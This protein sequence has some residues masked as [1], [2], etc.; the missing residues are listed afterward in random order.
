M[1]AVIHEGDVCD[2]SRRFCNP[3]IRSRLERLMGTNLVLL[4]D[5]IYMQRL[6]ERI[7]ED[8]EEAMDK[9]IKAREDQEMARV[10][11]LVLSGKI[12]LSQAPPEMAE[13]PVMLIENYCN[14]LIAERRAK[15][16][17]PRVKIPT[18]LYLD[19]TP[20]PPSGLSIEKGHIF[21]KQGDKMCIPVTTYLQSTEEED[22]ERGY[23]MTDEEYE[24][25]RYID[26]LVKEL[27]SCEVL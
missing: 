4:T 19:D 18:Y 20:D 24:Q 15:I 10:K 12:P 5:R 9:R 27:I 17:I 7:L 23:M 3:R 6:Q 25:L 8:Y 13:H 2:T 14:L 1:T 26:P 11:N 22:I 16:K 21:R